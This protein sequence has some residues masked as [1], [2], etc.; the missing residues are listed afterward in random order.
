[1]WRTAQRDEGVV[2]RLADEHQEAPAVRG[3]LGVAAAGRGV[4]P[5]RA[6]ALPVE[7]VAADRVV[8]VAVVSVKPPSRLFSVTKNSS[9][10]RSFR[11]RGPSPW[12]GRRCGVQYPDAV[13]TSRR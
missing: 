8:A 7:Q 10:L 13:S 4:F 5:D 2:T 11:R 12:L 3:L 9:V 6:L 1:M